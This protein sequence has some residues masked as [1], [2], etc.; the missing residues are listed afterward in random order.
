MK[1][2]YGIYVN[3]YSTIVKVVGEQTKDDGKIRLATSGDVSS[4]CATFF[5][6]QAEAEAA[7]LMRRDRKV[8]SLEL[9]IWRLQ[10]IT[11]ET[12]EIDDRT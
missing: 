12:V 1:T 10:K 4:L 2:Y 8:E 7:L 9:E 3:D 6:T 5:E 11:A